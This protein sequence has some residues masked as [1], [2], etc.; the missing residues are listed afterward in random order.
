MVRKYLKVLKIYSKKES[1]V[2]ELTVSFAYSCYEFANDNE[3][4]ETLQFFL[5]K[6]ILLFKQLCSPQNFFQNILEIFSSR[7]KIFV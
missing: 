7:V 1:K 3:A 4:H 5:T 6:I 2:L